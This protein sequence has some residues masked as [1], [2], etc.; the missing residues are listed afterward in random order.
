MFNLLTCFILM[1]NPL[2]LETKL[3]GLVGF[4]QPVNP[5]YAIIDAENLA[6][7]SGYYMTD[8]PFVKIESIKDSQDYPGI[9][10]ASFNSYLRNKVS[11]SIVN[12]ANAVFNENDFIDRQLLYKTA[13]NKFN[14][15]GSYTYDLTPGFICYWLQVSSEK[16]IAFKIK[17]V[18]LEFEGAG[19]ITI[20]L[21]NTANV[22]VPLQSKT[23]T[24]SSP[25]QEVDLDWVCDNSTAGKGYKGDYYLGYFSDGMTVKPFKREYRDASLMCDVAEMFIQRCQFSNF[26]SLDAAFELQNLSP[27]NPYNGINP[28]ITVYEDFTDLIVQNEKLFARAIMIDCQISLLLES[29]AT[30]RSNATQRIS[31]Q[32]VAQVMA[33]IEGVSGEVNVN[34]KGL[35]PQWF[36]A[37][38]S[39]R[40]EVQKLAIGYEGQGRI[41]VQTLS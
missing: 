32:Y 19:D 11:T 26:T 40:K 2:V 5:D 23:I 10:D 9:T 14:A 4:R 16:N 27:Y 36:G 8:N 3:A 30:L 33:Q 28:D 6:S 35:R 22:K 31:Q 7:R 21:F 39:I 34:V 38:G 24:I 1:I 12:V 29:V 41:M 13:L 20:H 18:L 17:R 37:I 15:G 25:F